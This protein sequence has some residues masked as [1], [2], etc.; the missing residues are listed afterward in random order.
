MRNLPVT[1]IIY[2]EKENVQTC[3]LSN[4]YLL[5]RI[6]MAKYFVAVLDIRGLELQLPHIRRGT[7]VVR[8]TVVR[9][10]PSNQCTH[11]ECC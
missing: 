11:L 2:E 9:F 6:V 3:L 4:H 1:E 5:D 8:A 10:S 7:I